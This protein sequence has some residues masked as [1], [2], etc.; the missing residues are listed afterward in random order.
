[1]SDLIFPVVDDLNRPFWD[2]CAAGELRLQACL[3]CGL[4]RYPI[5]DTCPRCLSHDADW[6]P[7]SGRGE[8]MSAVVFHRIY[9]QAWKD[10]VPYNVAMIQLAE[11][12]RMLGN[13]L[14]LDE[15]DLPAGTPVHVVFDASDGVVIPRWAPDGPG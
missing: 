7:L 4:I 3:R 1:M 10:R 11:G 2:G 9:N 5:S 6:R 13:V 15:R 14:P 8:I 12:P